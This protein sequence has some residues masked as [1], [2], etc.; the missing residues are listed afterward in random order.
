VNVLI[1]EDE[2]TTRQ[3][4]QSLLTKWGY[5]VSVVS[6][7]EEAWRVLSEAQQPLLVILDWMMPG[8]EGPELVRRLRLNDGG[9]QH[10][11]IIITSAS[12]ENAVAQALDAGADDFIRKPFNLNELRARIAVGNRIGCLHQALADKLCKLEEA[13]ESI[14]RLARTDD[15]TGLHNRRSFNEIFA[16]SLSSVRRHGQP[17]SLIS[18]DLDHFK[19]VNDNFGHSAGDQVLKDFSELLVKMVREEDV[20]ARWGGEEFIILLSHTASEAAT[21][22]AERIRCSFEQAPG[23]SSTL[24]MTASFGVAQLQDGESENDLIKRADDAL[25]RAKRAGRNRVVTAEGSQICR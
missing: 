7:G 15:L 5:N 4:L 14:S 2:A 22:L 12:S 6:D 16:L 23:R 3:I 24:A 11:V 18:I 17:L 25:Y 9:K 21:A 13:T 20:A 8:I 19:A 1:A 10:Y